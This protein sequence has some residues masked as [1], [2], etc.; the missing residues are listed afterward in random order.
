MKW[1]LFWH[2]FGIHWW[3]DYE[4]D[5][6]WHHTCYIC[7]LTQHFIPQCG[8]PAPDSGSWMDGTSYE[9]NDDNY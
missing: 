2:K 8:A 7:G 3:M 9:E 6:W 5:E 1:K 4:V